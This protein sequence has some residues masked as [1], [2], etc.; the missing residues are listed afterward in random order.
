ME[1]KTPPQPTD[2]MLSF[3]TPSIFILRVPTGGKINLS[4][5]GI[6]VWIVSQEIWKELSTSLLK[7]D[8]QTFDY[9]RGFSSLCQFL[10]LPIIVMALV[11]KSS[12]I[13]LF[14]DRHNSQSRRDGNKQ[15]KLI[16]DL[17]RRPPMNSIVLQTVRIQNSMTNTEEK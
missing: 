5:I 17:E 16:R 3:E 7:L 15:V 6:F 9:R 12:S 1:C 11:W 4:M 10:I 13:A 14:L 8:T 2:W